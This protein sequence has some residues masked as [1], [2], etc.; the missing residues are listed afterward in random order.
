MVK[1]NIKIL[2]FLTLLFIFVFYV[3]YNS[4]YYSV[5]YNTLKNKLYYAKESDNKDIII[6]FV[7]GLYTWNRRE[8]LLFKKFY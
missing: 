5:E 4:I 2:A 1:E 6:S 3:S 8:L 7:G